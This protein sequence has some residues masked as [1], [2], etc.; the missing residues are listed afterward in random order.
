MAQGGAAQQVSNGDELAPP[1]PAVA[2]L[3]QRDTNADIAS[4]NLNQPIARA[5]I[6][7]SAKRALL[8]KR[9]SNLSAPPRRGNGRSADCSQDRGPSDAISRLPRKGRHHNLAHFTSLFRRQIDGGT[10]PQRDQR[11]PPFR[12]NSSS[13]TGRRTLHGGPRVLG[14]KTDGC[15]M[16]GPLTRPR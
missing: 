8:G 11:P 15:S 3:V 6:T 4:A 5:Q 13:D 10:S 7:H 12:G 1:S 9:V 2:R 16:Y 14:D